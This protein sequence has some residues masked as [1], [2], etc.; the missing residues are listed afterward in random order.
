MANN[1]TLYI[2]AP[3]MQDVINFFERNKNNQTSF[4]LERITKYLDFPTHFDFHCENFN[5]SN[6]NFYKLKER[7]LKKGVGNLEFSAK[8]ILP[9]EISEMGDLVN[10]GY[11]AVNLESGLIDN[12]V[13]AR[14]L[15]KRK[16]FDIRFNNF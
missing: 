14:I 2:D 4:V 5:F 3:K 15:K 10:K 1:Y 12:P 13:E 8:V 11:L 6:D 9:K 16:K 7:N